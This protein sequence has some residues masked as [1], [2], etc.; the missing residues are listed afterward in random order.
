MTVNLER[1]PELQS[2]IICHGL[3]ALVRLRLGQAAEARRL[4]DETLAERWREFSRGA[5]DL[6]RD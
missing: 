4:A 1:R 5:L 3:L 2:E 6:G